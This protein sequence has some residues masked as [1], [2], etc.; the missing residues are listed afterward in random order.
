MQFPTGTF[1][2]S[3]ENGSLKIRTGRQGLGARAGHDLTLQAA[4]WEAVTRSEGAQP[5]VSAEVDLH[6]LQVMEGSGGMKPLTDGDRADIKKDLDKKILETDRYPRIAFHGKDWQVLS[7][8]ATHVRGTLSGQLELHGQTSPVELEVD[9]QRVD[10]VI[11]VKATT[12]VVQSKW[13]IKPFTAFL[14][15][16]K[17]AAPVQ[18]E[19][20]ATVPA[21]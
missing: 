16:L 11:Q 7:E 2:L 1:T 12:A 14:G 3:N 8:D 20:A 19:L 9:L 15:A 13:G 21:A 4:R 10:G 18:I 5:E 6:S 17:V